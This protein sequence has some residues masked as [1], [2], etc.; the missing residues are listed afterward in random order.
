[1]KITTLENNGD[2]EWFNGSSWVDVTL[3][4]VISAA[5]IG[6][7]RLRF[8]PDPDENGSNYATVGFMVSDGTSFSASA[9]TLTVNVTAVNDGP[10]AV[11]DTNAGDPV[12][13]LGVNPGNTA[14]AGDPSATGNVLDQRH[15]SRR[16]RQQGGARGCIRHAGGPLTGNVGRFV[17][18][19]YGTL[20]LAADGTWTYALDNLDGDTQALPQG[21]AAQDVFTYTMKDA[22]GA[23][24]TT[25][26]TINIT[27][28]ND[29]P[30]F[31]IDFGLAF[32]Q[33]FETNAAGILDQDDAWFGNVA[34]VP[35]GTNGIASPDGSSHAILTQTAPVAT[36]PAPS[37]GSTATA[38]SSSTASRPGQGLSRHRLG[39]GDGL[40]LFGRGD[41]HERRCTCATS[42]ST[43]PRTRRPASFWSP[44]PTTPTSTR[45]KTWR[46]SPHTRGLG[47]RLVHAPACVPQRR[48]Q[49]A[50]DPE[51]ARRGRQCRLH[52]RRVPMPPTDREH[53]VG[54]N[55]YGWFTNIDVAGGI[56][57]DTFTLDRPGP[58][59]GEVTE[60]V[61]TPASGAQLT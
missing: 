54:G 29:Q 11:A 57:V 37:P 39:S 45:G 61:G 47:V 8:V 46:R 53:R 30:V 59:K 49:L 50:V 5:D 4:Q 42:S 27:G 3:N 7:G 26:L 24:S 10:T 48:G 21:Q 33:G 17:A 16:R 43:S 32:D 56:A 60:I 36:I 51:P 44:P 34:I 15:R 6:A 28:T 20:T 13:E 2:L 9:Y 18:G 35:T 31:I 12:V 25:T 14:F 55:R 58:A 23:T 41:R 52:H 38:T 19:T 40:R 22:A 1:M